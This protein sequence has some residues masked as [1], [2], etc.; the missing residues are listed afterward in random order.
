[1]SENTQTMFKPEGL[2]AFP[3]E[4][5]E[6]DNSSASS[7]EK[8]NTEQT[9]SPE[10][11]SNSGVNKDDGTKE[12]RLAYHPRWKERE[13]DWLKRFNDQEVRHTSEIA[14][15]R[16]D[17]EAKLSVKNDTKTMP[18]TVPSWFGGDEN[19]WNEYQE[20]ERLKMS[21]LREETLKE[22]NSKSV[23]EQKAID[24]ATTY[25]NG[26]VTAI[27]ADKGINPEG[28]KVDRNK[29]LKF[30]LDEKLVDTEGRWNYRAAFKMMKA[31]DVFK[32]K[33]ILNE[34]KQIAS[35]TTSENRA[36]SK[37]AQYVTSKD[38]AN[39]NKRPW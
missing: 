15:L 30:V 33:E 20:H 16:E 19:Q 13:N 9:Q 6:N 12:D 39:P 27:E 14:K 11:E 7:T 32:A 31:A 34:K 26:E 17:V 10:G 36:E 8:T 22:F 2:P 1:M 24:E 3:V 29:L 35:A 21:K 25:M 18:T 38:F 37:P 5:K 23:A 4:N 28:Q